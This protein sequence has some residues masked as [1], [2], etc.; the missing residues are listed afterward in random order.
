[1]NTSALTVILFAVEEKMDLLVDRLLT[2]GQKNAR[3]QVEKQV[4]ILLFLFL[5]LSF[6]ICLKKNIGVVLMNRALN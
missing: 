5:F 2:T 6:E 1:M 3:Q 4:L